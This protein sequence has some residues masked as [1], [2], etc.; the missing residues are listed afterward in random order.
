MAHQTVLWT[1]VPDG[2]DN[3]VAKIV[4]VVS[5]RLSDPAGERPVSAY[6]D[7]VNW[8]ER[9]A[10]VTFQVQFDDRAPVPATVLSA[11]PQPAR[12]AALVAPELAVRPF[13]PAQH[14]DRQL[15]SY[16]VGHVV[17]YL[18]HSYLT[19]ALTSPTEFPALESHLGDGLGRIGLAFD[20]KTE[21]SLRHR[22]AV[23][24]KEAKAIPPGAAAPVTD[25]LQAVIF[26]EVDP[27]SR[28]LPAGTAQPD[29]HQL[30]TVLHQYPGLQRRL[31]LVFDLAVPL[32]AAQGAGTVRVLPAWQPTLAGTVNLTPATRT[33]LAGQRFSPQPA[34]GS[35]L[36]QD[37]LPL[38]GDNF[39]VITMDADGA[40]LKARQFADNLR[41]SLHRRAADTPARASLPALRSAGLAVIRTGR[42][43]Q[44]ARRFQVAARREWAV[45]DGDP[46]T[47]D[48][49]ALLYGLR[50]AVY[51]VSSG[52]WYSLCER[53]GS[54]TF[55]RDRALD[56]QLADAGSL[57]TSVT[58]RADRPTGDYYLA[59]Y[60]CRWHGESLV[61]PRPGRSLD[62][63]PALPPVHPPNDPPASLPLRVDVVPE[64][65]SLPPLRYGRRYRLRA[66]ASY[67]GGA[68]PRSAAPQPAGDFGHATAEVTFARLEPVP[69]PV[70]VMRRPRGPGESLHHVVI[71]SDHD[72]AAAATRPTERHLLPPKTSQLTAETHGLFDTPRG[73]DRD[74]YPTIVARAGGTLAGGGAP[75]PADHDQRYYDTDTLSFPVESGTAEV[76]WLVDPL[77]RGVAL[78]GLPGAAG[79][80]V[81]VDFGY[82]SGRTWRTLRPVRLRLVEGA[83][84]ASF[85]PAA[86]VL[87]VALGKADTAQVAISCLVG[88][89]DL[90]LL[91][92]WRWIAD[93]GLPTADLARHR[94]YALDGRNWLLTPAQPVTLVHAVRRPLAAPVFRTVAAERVPGSAVCTLVADRLAI[95]RKSTVSLDVRAQW[96]DP[97][98]VLDAAGWQPRRLVTRTAQ[99][100]ETPVAATDAA[101]GDTAMDL[102][103]PHDLGDTGFHQ[104][105]YTA[106]AKSRFAE[107]FTE[108]ATA[109]LSLTGVAWQ[110]LDGTGVTPGSESVRPA[111]GGAAYAHHTDYELDPVAGTIRRVDG[112]RVPAGATVDVS[113]LP[114][115]SRASAPVTV[116]VRASARPAP[117]APLYVV[118]TFGWSTKRGPDGVSSH[119]RG[120]GLRVY[121]D[122]PWW[123]SGD[124]ETLGVVLWS[125]PPDAGGPDDSLRPYVTGWGMDP[126]YRAAA[127]ASAVPGPADFPRALVTG[128]AVPLAECAA[129]VAVAGH[130]VV[131]DPSRRL[132]FCDVE[133][134][135]GP[136]HLPFVR[137]A[138]ARYQPQALPGAELSHVVLA[139]FAQLAPDRTATVVFAPAQGA[140]QVSVVGNGYALTADGKTF[141]GIEVTVERRDRQ[142]PGE[143][144][145]QAA[146]APQPLPVV[147]LDGGEIR[148]T[149]PVT[150]PV[151]RGSEPMRLVI[152][153]YDQ[154][155]GG[156]RLTYT[157]VLDV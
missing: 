74:A 117:P 15:R 25:F 69:P 128:A 97:V 35:D 60:L 5:P 38:G 157:D 17:D 9:A 76:P 87:T 110:P 123:S 91:E 20:E 50:W 88:A 105:T 109:R 113:Y 40:A 62:R 102:R 56:L 156:R 150:L 18:R 4:C 122:R 135:P 93:A 153:E 29:L 27:G 141:G 23:L 100:G 140:L 112:G 67:L 149:G 63:D 121:L 111:G 144:G 43:L 131:P 26:H 57:T 108:P 152:R 52:R 116:S 48:A 65:G 2:V 138:L 134:P 96:T 90:P 46:V 77:A 68:G 61:A 51:D 147:S 44:Q 84:A 82:A 11:P 19:A 32:A 92:I 49:D 145:W 80:V 39:R 78:H 10:R 103:L 130:A 143:L 95:S 115:V 81:T 12:W 124:G 101:L 148:W 55:T 142:I 126:L 118:P 146:D 99:L 137:L 28:R 86:R 13:E 30:L 42:A 155:P 59:E 70:L 72:T 129:V 47:L 7:W 33:T 120:G 104:V 53:R 133:L 58:Q 89:A 136:A 1:A 66:T 73:L 125:G 24:R 36:D 119:R 3:G 154:L 34:V 75:D 6:P 22:L 107:Y 127:T 64:P 37:A 106:S 98:D 16:P 21:A 85:D 71:R 151:P 31:G 54:Y 8:A 14:A 139:E 45:R 79:E 114:S 132:W 83:A 41:R 94:G